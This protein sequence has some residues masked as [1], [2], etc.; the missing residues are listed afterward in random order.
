MFYCVSRFIYLNE[1]CYTRAWVRI[2]HY[3]IGERVELGR[4]I[5]GRSIFFCLGCMLKTFFGA[6]RVLSAAGKSICLHFMV[7]C[8]IRRKNNSYHYSL[9]VFICILTRERFCVSTLVN[10]C[11]V[12][13]F[14]AVFKCIFMLSGKV[15]ART[16]RVGPQGE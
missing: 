7:S 5:L 2:S 8:L 12:N 1:T 14:V 4:P 11:G 13:Y 16:G 15:Y 6:H 10:V 9:I 3:V